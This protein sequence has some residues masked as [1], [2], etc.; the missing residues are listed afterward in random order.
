MILANWLEF[1]RIFDTTRSYVL[2]TIIETRGSTY[3]KTGAMMLVDELG[4]CFGLLS[5]GCLE[6]DISLHAK[7]VLSSNENVLLSYDLKADADLLWGLGLGCE[8]AL[9]ILLIPITPHN[10]HQSF[11]KLLDSVASHQSGV[12]I[13]PC[14]VSSN[15]KQSSAKLSLIHI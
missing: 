13:L 9:D 12:Y 4:N 1:C 15:K 2:A 7:S 8:G 10:R 14:D 6:A 5:G 11:D 3:Q